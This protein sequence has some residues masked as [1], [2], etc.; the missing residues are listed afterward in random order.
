MLFL[1]TPALASATCF[2]I[3]E[4]LARSRIPRLVREVAATHQLSVDQLMKDSQ[5]VDSA[6]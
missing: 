1:V 2:A 6:M 5:H 3:A 4:G